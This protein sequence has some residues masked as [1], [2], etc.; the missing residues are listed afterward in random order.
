MEGA[1]VVPAGDVRVE[2]VG[3]EGGGDAQLRV[4]LRGRADGKADGMLQAFPGEAFFRGGMAEEGEELLRVLAEL[5]AGEGLQGFL[6]VRGGQGG[7][8]GA[9]LAQHHRA[10]DPLGMQVPLIAAVGTELAVHR[11]APAAPGPGEGHVFHHAGGEGAGLGQGLDAQGLEEPHALGFRFRHRA[12]EEP[13]LRAVGLGEGAA[14]HDGPLEEAFIFL[15]GHLGADAHAA[16]ALTADGDVLRVAAE[17]RDVPLD[18]AGG[19]L[20]IQETEVGGGVGIFCGD[21]RMAEEAEAVQPVADGDH[22]HAAAGDAFA[23]KL[24]LGGVAD[25]QSAAE[26]PDVHGEVLPPVRRRPDVEVQAVLGHGELRVHG[27]FPGVDVLHRVAGAV[28][29]HGDGPEVRREKIALPVLAGLGSTPAVLAHRRCGK[30]NALVTGDAG[31][32]GRQSANPAV[33]GLHAADHAFHSVYVDK[34]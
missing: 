33:L 10:D 15:A 8:F 18:P 21:L 28:G 23:V 34:L 31:I 12:G 27:P 13:H 5:L 16:G 20:L 9:G 24:H 17:G 2:I 11:F 14:L 25:L 30:G 6:A 19:A 7:E 4:F 3:V 26:V 22:H 32:G 1:R 29:L